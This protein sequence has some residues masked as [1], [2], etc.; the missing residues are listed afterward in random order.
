MD[1]GVLSGTGGEVEQ[2]DCVGQPGWE[3]EFVALQRHH[4]P[5]SQQCWLLPHDGAKRPGISCA[6]SPW[7]HQGLLHPFAAYPQNQ[8]KGTGLVLPR[9]S[10]LRVR[11]D[12]H[13]HEGL[14]AALLGGS[15]LGAPWSEGLL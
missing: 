7:P 13:K 14:Q 4:H 3:R 2:W 6:H 15:E 5:V 8:S 12:Q 9:G 1:N 11:E 10:R